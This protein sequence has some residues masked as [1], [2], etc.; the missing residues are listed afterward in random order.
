MEGLTKEGNQC[1]D[2]LLF[3]GVCLNMDES[4]DDVIICSECGCPMFYI[5][6]RIVD[7]MIGIREITCAN[8]EAAT[9]RDTQ[10]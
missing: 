3:T 2:P 9:T 4:E 8:C 5:T 1:S 7:D 6:G 10:H